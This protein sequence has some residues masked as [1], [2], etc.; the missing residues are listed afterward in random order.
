MPRSR[1][2]PPSNMPSANHDTL[3]HRLVAILSKL[4]QGE[5]LEPK[6]LA[7]EFN[8]SLR[9][10]QRDLHERFLYL[11]LEQSE[12]KFRLHPSF[13][14]KLTLKDVHHFAALAGVK[15][16]FPGLSEEFLRDIFHNRVH[17]SLMVK[18]HHY[19]DLRGKEQDFK[20][21]E[22]A[23]ADHLE[24][25]FEYPVEAGLKP[26][27]V[28]PYK[29]VN[30]KGVWYLAAKHHEKLK[31]FSFTKLERITVGATTFIPDASVDARLA[32]EDG[33]WLSANPIDVVLKI[34][35]SVAGYFKRRTLVANQHITREFPDG[36]ILLEARVG[37]PNQ[38]M[39]IVRYWIPNIQIVSPP[40]LQ[41]E[42]E[43]TLRDYLSISKD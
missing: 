12:G 22:K 30:N 38:V 40:G 28:E 16:L 43:Q 41:D 20:T 36:S 32:Q 26:Y 17:D 6:A 42:L 33:I 39:P 5:A 1:V 15:G 9:T 24:V 21:V 29:L 13:L 27:V 14:G 37:H 11:P 23:I 7:L 3:V 35:P 4:N 34:N 19:E 18:G 25:S 31:T 10:I 2:A 8:V